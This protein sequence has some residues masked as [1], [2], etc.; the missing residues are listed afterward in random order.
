M[1]DT[2]RLLFFFMEY[3]ASADLNP[4]P[5]F[6]GTL[7]QIPSLFRT[8]NNLKKLVVRQ[9]HESIP[10]DVPKRHRQLCTK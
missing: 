7:G 2:T 6:L 4:A 9:W 3:K 5:D 1:L 8:N 10:L